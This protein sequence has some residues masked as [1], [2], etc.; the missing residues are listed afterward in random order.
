MNSGERPFRLPPP[1]YGVFVGVSLSHPPEPREVPTPPYESSVNLHSRP[2]N[3]P[4]SSFPFESHSQ[5]LAPIRELRNTVLPPIN[6]NPEAVPHTPPHIP[7]PIQESHSVSTDASGMNLTETRGA[8]SDN[9]PFSIQTISSASHVHNSTLFLSPS[10]F[11]FL[12]L[13][14][15]ISPFLGTFITCCLAKGHQRLFRRALATSCLVYCLCLIFGGSLVL[16]SLDKLQCGMVIGVV[17]VCVGATSGTLGYAI[18]RRERRQRQTGVI[19]TSTTIHII[20][21]TRYQET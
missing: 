10:F 3:V 4:S 5:A 15:V 17:M 7:Q 9:A 16:W 20:E 1:R 21:T 18:F 12:S 8:S 19:V 13:C 2:L 11:F 14:L 6:S